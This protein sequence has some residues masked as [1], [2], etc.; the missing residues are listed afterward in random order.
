[1]EQEIFDPTLYLDR[2]SAC[3]HAGKYDLVA[4]DFEQYTQHQESSPHSISAARHAK[5]FVS[6]LKRGAY[7]SGEQTLHLLSDTIKHPIQTVGQMIESV[8]VL[9]KLTL[10]GEGMAIFEGLAPEVKDLF[11]NWNNISEEQRIEDL[12]YCV[13]KYGSDILTPGVIGKVGKNATKVARAAKNLRNAKKLILVESA[14]ASGNVSKYGKMMVAAQKNA[15][16]GKELAISFKEMRKLHKVGK[17]EAVLYKELPHLRL[18][19]NKSIVFFDKAQKQLKPFIKKPLHEQVVRSYIHKTG[20]STF[21]KPENIPKNYLVR[22][23]ERGAGMEYFH[24]TNTHLKVRVMPGK[25]HSPFPH[26]QRPYVIQMKDGKAFNK[27][28]KLIEK[29]KAEAHIP[30]EEYTYRK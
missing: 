9:A 16:I 30:L 20:I 7:D 8:G 12:G 11:V 18:S 26:Q 21:F 6:G 19:K 24:P 14:V 17:L 28:G 27:K 3:L 22:V 23:T 4:S 25:S 1:M 2:S 29:N 15:S 5:L 13:G 10:S